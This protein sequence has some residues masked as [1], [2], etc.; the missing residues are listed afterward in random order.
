M[1]I[2]WIISGIIVFSLVEPTI[3]VFT[4]SK[5]VLVEFLACMLLG[6][7]IIPILALGAIGYIIGSLRRL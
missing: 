4:F 3:F 2:Y 6:G 7:L 1:L 5:D